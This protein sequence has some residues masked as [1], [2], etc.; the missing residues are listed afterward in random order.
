L[1]ELKRRERR[2]PSSIRETI[3][4]FPTI[5]NI[6][7]VF[8]KIGQVL[9]LVAALSASG[10]HWLALQ[11]VAWS[12]MLAENL[13]T[14]SWQ[15]ALTRTFDGKHPCCLCRQIA[16][17]KQSE[18]K[19][20]AQVESQKFDFFHVASEFV[21]CAPV[22]FYETRDSSPSSDSLTRSPSVPPPKALPA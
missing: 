18:K 2:S 4:E 12:T 17:D 1:R 3:D 22:H 9:M 20:D 21:F 15:T 19:S 5:N 14:S 8:R 7:R 16:Q 10:T 11:S 13:Q 6:C